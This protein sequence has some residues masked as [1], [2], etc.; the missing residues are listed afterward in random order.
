[1][2]VDPAQLA[3]GRN[4]AGPFAARAITLPAARPKKLSLGVRRGLSATQL[5]VPPATPQSGEEF[6]EGE[7][8]SYVLQNALGQGSTAVAYT[9]SSPGG[10]RHVI[11][12]MKH[13][14][15]ESLTALGLEFRMLQSLSH[16]H[17]IRARDVALDASWMAL[18]FLEQ[19]QKLR[20]RVK[21]GGAL[22]PEVAAVVLRNLTSA[23]AYIH[24]RDVGHRDVNPENVLL[25]GE[26]GDMRLIDFN[27]AHAE[28]TI[29][30]C[31]SP[32]GNPAYMAPEVLREGFGFPAD[33]WGIGATLYFAACGRWNGG[34]N[35]R[36]LFQ[37]PAWVA[38]PALL[39]RSIGC[40]LENNPASRPTASAL[41]EDLAATSEDLA[42]SAA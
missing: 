5:Y 12:K 37:E 20:V 27:A 24:T 33:V 15:P 17:I 16:P 29:D 31:L 41:L 28:A 9:A 40:C 21:A 13:C 34:W 35:G 11:K 6:L 14:D 42:A 7:I 18:E 39:R 23:V 4:P 3:D 38:A 22:Q 25:V 32:G 26:L 8:S 2:T 1:M 10:S 36:E 19:S 30:S